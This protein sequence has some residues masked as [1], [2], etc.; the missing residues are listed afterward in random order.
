VH[1]FIAGIVFLIHAFIPDILVRDGSIIIEKIAS[2]IMRRNLCDENT[3]CL[4]H[5]GLALKTAVS[6]DMADVSLAIFSG[7][8]QL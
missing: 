4:C 3:Q 1:S 7:F 5:K 6:T 8:N 2:S